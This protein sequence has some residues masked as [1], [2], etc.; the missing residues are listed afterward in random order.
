MKGK[1][2]KLGSKSD[3]EHLRAPLLPESDLCFGQIGLNRAFF[4]LKQG[5]PRKR[6]IQ[7]STKRASAVPSVSLQDYLRYIEIMAK[8]KV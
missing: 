2:L 5:F 8:N 4:F 6:L 1:L 3:R 7:G